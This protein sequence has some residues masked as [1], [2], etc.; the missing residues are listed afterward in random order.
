MPFIHGQD[1]SYEV[2][3]FGICKKMIDAK[4]ESLSAVLITGDNYLPAEC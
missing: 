1:A 3:M 2:E 4:W